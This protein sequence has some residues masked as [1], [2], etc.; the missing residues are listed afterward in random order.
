MKAF[1][2]AT[3]DLSLILDISPQRVLAISADSNLDGNDVE[4]KGKFKF[5]SPRGVRK[6]LHRKGIVSG[7]RKVIAFCNN[8]GGVGK[9]SIASNTALMLSSLGFKTLLIDSD[10]QANTTSFF[11]PDEEETFCLMEIL[12][13]KKTIEKAIH[14]LTPTLHI[15]PSNLNNQKLSNFLSGE[16]NKANLKELIS[17]L[18]YDYVIWDCNPSLDST[19]QQIYY[20]CTD[21]IIVTLMEAWSIIGVEMTKELL[22]GLFKNSTVKIPNVNVLINKLDNRIASQINL[23]SR[24]EKLQLEV[25]PITIDT[26]NSIPKSQNEDFLLTNKNKTFKAFLELATVLISGSRPQGVDSKKLN[27]D[28]PTLSV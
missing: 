2:I 18:D 16:P 26:D 13:G 12:N 4:S 24:L 27:S 11:L 23:Y 10:G 19:N 14:E 22:M 28:Y 17:T 6:I 15:L 21:V 3:S 7:E 9:S 1:K 8:K 25:F 20:S 5:Y